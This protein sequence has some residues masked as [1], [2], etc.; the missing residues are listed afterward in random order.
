MKDVYQYIPYTLDTKKWFVRADI[1]H[2]YLGFKHRILEESEDDDIL[3]EHILLSQPDFDIHLDDKGIFLF[4]HIL[5]DYFC[6]DT[7]RDLMMYVMDKNKIEQS[8]IIIKNVA[9]LIPTTLVKR[10][11]KACKAVI[12]SPCESENRKGDAEELL[13]YFTDEL[14]R[15]KGEFP[16]ITLYRYI[17]YK[18]KN[19][20]PH[21]AVIDMVAESEV[22]Q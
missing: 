13:R 20:S 10:N 5:E 9:A 8:N 6:I 11:I 14:K 19:K 7:I 12:E 21:K 4:S 22:T 16:F 3:L 17:R 1:E 15:R 2:L 18:R